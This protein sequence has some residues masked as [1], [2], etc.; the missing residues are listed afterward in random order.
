MVSGASKHHSQASRQGCKDA[1]VCPFF[2][3]VSGSQARVANIQGPIKFW[4]RPFI[5]FVNELNLKIV[6]FHE[7][8]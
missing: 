3:I 2:A 4:A 1:C 7:T 6:S 5:L 8:H